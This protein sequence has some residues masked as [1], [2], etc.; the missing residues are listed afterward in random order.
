MAAIL[1]LSRESFAPLV[2][3]LA[4]GGH[5]VLE[6][7]DSGHILQMV[8]RRNPDAIILPEDGK[9]LLPLIRRLTRAAIVVAGEGLDESRRAAALMQ[10]ADAFLLYPDDPA[11]LRSR[12]R[13]TLRR[14]GQGAAETRGR[15][16]RGSET[17]GNGHGHQMLFR[18]LEM[19]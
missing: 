9:E 13:A 6:A 15:G 4:E 3:I 18:L 1:I 14:A 10:G 17:N 5:Q 8:M 2:A 11:R 7:V 12:I 16:D 19:A